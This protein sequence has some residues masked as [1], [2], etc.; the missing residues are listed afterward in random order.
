MEV[1]AKKGPET[2]ERSREI[3][4]AKTGIKDIMAGREAWCRSL[5]K[6]RR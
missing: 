1:E 2:G 4:R 6:C 5:L 3:K